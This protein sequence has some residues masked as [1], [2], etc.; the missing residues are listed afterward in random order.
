M[1]LSA[2]A[3]YL[4]GEYRSGSGNRHMRVTRR[5]QSAHGSIDE[6]TVMRPATLR[7]AVLLG[8]ALLTGACQ[9]GARPSPSLTAASPGAAEMTIALRGDFHPVDDEASG[10][11]ELVQL[12]DGS[13][14][15]IFESFSI[16]TTESLKVYLVTNEDVTASTDVDTENVI[17]LGDLM[18]TSGMQVYPFPPEM[19]AD[20][21]T[22]QTVVIWDE[23]MGH[24]IAAAPLG[25]P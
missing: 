5:H 7:L 2:T 11:A 15:V 19:N 24:A 16:A 14:E 22:Y 21:M 17:D 4:L 18:G 20:V 10:V 9:A 23:P 12:A 8:L 6:E 1:A 25:V 13:Y 3:I